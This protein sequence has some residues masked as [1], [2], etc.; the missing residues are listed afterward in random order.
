MA[1]QAL[2]SKRLLPIDSSRIPQGATPQALDPV[3]RDDPATLTGGIAFASD[4]GG[5]FDLYEQMADGSGGSVILI[6]GTHNQVTPAW[7]PDGQRLIFASDQDGDFDIYLRTP[8]NQ[9]HNLTNNDSAD[10]HPAWSPANDR[11]YFASNRTGGYFRIYSMQPNGSDV[12]EVVAAANNHVLAPS[13]SPDGS[14][15]AYMR[16]SV[17]EP[18]CQWNWDVWV[19]NSDGRNPQRLTNH[20]A[21]DLYPVWTPDGSE[22]VLA[23]CRNFLDFDLYAVNVATGGQRRLTNWFLI[24]E[25]GASYA[26]DGVNLAFSSDRGGNVDVY[27]MPATGGAASNLT[28]HPSEDVAP[29]WRDLGSSATYRV[30]GRVLD[31]RGQGVSEVTVSDNAGHSTMT[32]ADGD[33]ALEN[34]PAGL[35]TLTPVRPGFTFNPRFVQVRVPPSV[36][37]LEFRGYDKAPVVFVHGWQGLNFLNAIPFYDPNDTFHQVDDLLRASG[38]ETFFAQLVT[39]PLLTP[40][41]QDNVPNLT[42]TINQAKQATNQE[43]VILVAHSMGGLVSR[44]YLESP[45][46]RGDVL[47]VFTF[48]TPHHGVPTDVLLILLGAFTENGLSAYCTAY[49]PAV[50]EFSVLGMALFN[51]LHPHRAVGVAY[52][53]VSGDIPWSELELPSRLIGLLLPGP[54]DG[55]VPTVSGNGRWLDRVYDRWITAEAHGKGSSS[56]SYFY[57]EGR[58]DGRTQSYD[59]CLEVTLVQGRAVCQAARLQAEDGL[60]QEP[61]LIPTPL[62]YGVLLPTGTAAHAVTID[63][64]PAVFATQWTTGTLAMTLVS[65]SGQLI[66]PA[67]AVSHPEVVSYETAPSWAAYTFSAAEAGQ[68]QVQ[69]RPVTVPSVGAAYAVFALFTSDLRLSG[70]VDQPWYRP[71]ATAV[72]TATLSV[73]AAGTSVNATILLANGTS[74]QVVLTPI[75]NKRFRGVFSVPDVPG[76]GEVRFLAQG[77]RGGRHF[78]RGASTLFQI[79]PST[80]VLNGTYRDEPI[81]RGPGT[82][83]YQALRIDVGLNVTRAGSYSVSADLVDSASNL[84]AQA[85]AGGSFT[86]GT[87]TVSLTFSGFDIFHSGRDGPYTLTNVLLADNRGPILVVQQAQRVYTTRFYAARDFRVGDLFLPLVS[88]R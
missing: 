11:I 72:L 69:L 55:L 81:L 20:L 66:D 19:V 29:S 84:V 23:S 52:H 85:A 59:E 63:A 8:D 31:A 61:A 76:Y 33:F 17:L 57:W 48:G 12:S 74:R 68:W 71:G 78:E 86:P 42:N 54:D 32:N 56:R 65:P 34:L 7:S 37:G 60:N 15:I 22:V 51:Q 46:Y 16:A 9:V 79:S 1:V 43:K 36:A 24:N 6:S 28:R 49:Q 87:Q 30:A 5:D 39:S 80:A 38:R 18:L 14:R 53:L 47:E 21:A 77:T 75:D 83:V 44:A 58:T 70:E 45:E 73:P 40:P 64:G 13:V 3:L 67:Y 27:T 62:R 88:K 50:C 4:R 10:V 82:A 2:L 26:P 25:W 35:H 41:I